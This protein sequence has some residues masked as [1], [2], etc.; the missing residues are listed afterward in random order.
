MK[1]KDLKANIIS[2]LMKDEDIENK[3]T[4]MEFSMMEKEMHEFMHI[5]DSVVSRIEQ[6]EKMDIE[7]ISEDDLDD[8]ELLE[9]TMVLMQLT[10]DIQSVQEVYDK[11][12]GE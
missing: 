5:R 3:F 1:N 12:K 4:P 2:I 7:N 11:I 10:E 6:L 9:L 8:D